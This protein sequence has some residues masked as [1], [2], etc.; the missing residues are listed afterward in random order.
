MSHINFSYRR[1]VFEIL[2]PKVVSFVYFCCCLF[3][4]LLLSE[5]WRAFIVVNL[6]ARVKLNRI[7]NIYFSNNFA[8]HSSHIFFFISWFKI[9]LYPK[10]RLYNILYFYAMELLTTMRILLP[11]CSNSFSQRIA[12]HFQAVA[13][14]YCQLPWV[15]LY[16]VPVNFQEKLNLL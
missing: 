12:S 1:I 10:Y 11:Y 16:V 14:T 9:L 8:Q 13:K 6:V 4:Y 15:V 5:F 3:Y 2:T 7:V